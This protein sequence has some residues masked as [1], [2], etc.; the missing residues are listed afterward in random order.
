MGWLILP[1]LWAPG[2]SVPWQ[3]AEVTRFSWTLSQ[4]FVA[5][6]HSPCPRLWVQGVWEL[7]WDLSLCLDS[8][9]RRPALPLS[10]LLPLHQSGISRFYKAPEQLPR[11]FEIFIF[12]HVDCD[13]IPSARLLKDICCPLC[14]VH[15]SG[16]LSL[17]VSD[18]PPRS[19][20]RFSYP[21]CLLPTQMLM[22][23][24]VLAFSVSFLCLYWNQ[25]GFLHTLFL[26]FNYHSSD[27]MVVICLDIEE[28]AKLF[29]RETTILHSHQHSILLS[30]YFDDGNF[31]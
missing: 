24:L 13:I 20:C 1:C 26:F 5:K 14:H 31:G 11:L 27:P 25:N 23:D 21:Q 3:V 22:T 29:S 9:S 10:K 8:D 28:T 2:T 18:F 6:A 7:A 12:Y 17:T 4:P 15:R 30:C 16:T 19:T